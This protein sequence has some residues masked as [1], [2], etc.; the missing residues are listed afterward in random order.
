MDIEPQS[1]SGRT[2]W[3]ALAVAFQVRDNFIVVAKKGNSEGVDF[4]VLCQEGLHVMQE[5]EAKDCWG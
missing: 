3:Q 2:D 5:A 4:Y 1:L